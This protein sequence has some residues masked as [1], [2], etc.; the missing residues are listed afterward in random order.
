[1]E[2]TKNLNLNRWAPEDFVRLTQ[3]N[4]NFDKIDE[5]VGA[6]KMEH[7]ALGTYTGDGADSRTIELPFAPKLAILMGYINQSAGMSI[8]TQTNDRF[9]AS[10]GGGS[11]PQFNAKLKNDT[12]IICNRFWHNGGG[13]T[14]QY[15]LLG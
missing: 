7:L 12:L 2:Q 10:S 3:I 14:I 6:L 13:E 1:M 9:I 8:L 11:S 4:Q 5:E 15:I